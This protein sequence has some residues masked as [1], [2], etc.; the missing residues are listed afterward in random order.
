MKNLILLATLICLTLT[1]GC[2]PRPFTPPPECVG[3]P[4]LILENT[5]DPAALDKGLLIINL[6]ALQ[7]VKGYGVDDAYTVLD[8]VDEMLKIAGTSYAEVAVY[9]LAKAKI[10]NALAGSLIFI[11]GPDIENLSKPIPINPCDIAL[12]RAHLAKQRML[13]ALYAA[14]D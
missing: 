9:I 4:S 6:A 3:Q 7:A 1:M 2:T 5:P 10:A 14:G 12:I 13:L 11:V 8:Q